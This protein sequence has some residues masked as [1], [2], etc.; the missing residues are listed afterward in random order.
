MSLSL[1]IP[2]FSRRFRAAGAPRL[3]ALER[4][5][6]R[7]SDR[8]VVDPRGFLAPLFGLDTAEL[9]EAPF[10]RLADAGRAD[11]GYW[12]CADPVHLAPDRD[13]LVL[14]TEPLLGVEA[15]E[16][17][18]LAAAFNDLYS[19]EGRQLESGQA[20]RWYLRCPRPLSVITYDPDAV[21][22]G[23]V[24]EFMPSGADAG[25]LK[26]LMNEVQMLFHTHA[27][28]RL[29]EEAGRPP[30][31]SLWLWGGGVLPE[32]R[33]VPPR[34]VWAATP[35]LR[36]LALWSGIQPESL[37]E[38]G[39]GLSGTGVF[40]LTGQDP[41]ELDYRWFAPLLSALQRGALDV[42]D[43]YLGGLGSFVLS[44]N[45]ARRFW[46]RGGAIALATDE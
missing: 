40:D 34:Q 26:R 35:L 2:D 5:R 15:E 38:S 31:N 14:M 30:I 10:M 4:M 13:Q 20:G 43:V 16:A 46:R 42:L 11:P 23:S 7:A 32:W 28:N 27:V 3:P 29:R 1:F 6:A 33:A 36:G 18:A 17:A 24:L 25:Q 44:R 39:T 21:A 45:A 37:P 22:G 9:A 41:E 12:L 8:R 19:A